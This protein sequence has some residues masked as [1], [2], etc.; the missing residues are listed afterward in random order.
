[1][2]MS[3]IKYAAFGKVD[4]KIIVAVRSKTGSAAALLLELRIRIPPGA[5]MFMLCCCIRTVVWNMKDR[6]I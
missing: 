3:L 1:M 2:V 5:W 4:S 6:R